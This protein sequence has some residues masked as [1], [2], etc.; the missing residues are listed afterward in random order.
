MR[1]ASRSECQ[2]IDRR[3]QSEY[4]VSAE[5][6]MEAAGVAAATAIRE[7]YPNT[8]SVV[9][10]C[11]PGNNGGDGL[12]VARQLHST[13]RPGIQVVAVGPAEKRSEPFQLQLERCRKCGI[14][15]VD[16]PSAGAMEAVQQASL[17][18]DAIFGIGLRG[19]VN[20]PYRG[21]I[22]AINESAAPVVSLDTPS[23]LDADRGVK[24]G[25]A[26][27]AEQTLT[28]GVAKRGFYIGDGP[29]LTGRVKILPIGFPYQLV[30]EVAVQTKLFT[31]RTA[32]YVL[33]RRRARTH[34]ATYGHALIIA[35]S[36]GMWGAGVLSAHAAYRMG[37]GYVTLASSGELMELSATEP[38]ILTAD[39][40]DE[41]IWNSPRW[42]A[43]AVGPGL[44]V[45]DQTEELLRRLVASG[46]PNVVVDADAITVAA[47][48][49]LFPFPPTWILTPHTGELSR[50]LGMS[51]EE[52]EADRFEA[53]RRA[54]ERTGCIVL[55]K[56]F[57]TIV[58]RGPCAWVIGSGNS[59]LAKAGTGDVLTGMIVGLLAQGLRPLRAAAAAAYVHGRLADDWVKTGRSKSS[60]VAKDLYEMLPGLLAKLTG[61]A[62]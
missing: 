7:S 36:P 18:V 60:L 42:R 57:R 29:L 43:A 22:L 14:A 15:I 38:E 11:G 40:F 54:T 58:A 26:V 27:R 44:G 33:P 52:I 51:A 53:V 55:L 1:L 16:Y 4:G 56:G 19:E 32:R 41:R 25:V 3:S 45:S 59:T 35:G 21:L 20:D 17:I 30:R 13:G 48:R 28:F 2:E 23:G 6:L 47:Q 10:V 39:A 24:C 37:A 12:V 62:E 34:K 8:T 5:I 50:I 61:E 31:S 49:G 46:C 9:V